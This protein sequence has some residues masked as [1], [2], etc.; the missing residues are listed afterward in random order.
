MICPIMG[1][2]DAANRLGQNES[3]VIF[4]KISLQVRFFSVQF[5]SFKFSSILSNYL[6]DQPFREAKGCLKYLFEPIEQ[7]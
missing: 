7:G 1:V 3:P 5:A 2:V 6:A 4:K